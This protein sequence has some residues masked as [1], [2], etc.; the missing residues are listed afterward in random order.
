MFVALAATTPVP[1][2]GFA[3]QS[4]GLPSRLCWLLLFTY[5]YVFVIGQEFQRLRRAAA[6]RCFRPRT[7][8]R[9]YKT[10]AH[11]FA[12]TLVRSWDRAER[13]RDAMAVRGFQGRFH[14]LRTFAMRRA[15][16]ALLGALF[17]AAAGLALI[18]AVS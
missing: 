4:L 12:M 11:L 3:L 9:T 1:D 2:L 10:Y 8:L 14:S 5:R 7:D 17:L 13:V 18:Q 16:K 15:D 6:M